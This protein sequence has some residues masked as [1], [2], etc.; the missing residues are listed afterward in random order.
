MKKILSFVLLLAIF[1]T[2][3]SMLPVVSAATVET[4]T[5][6]VEVTGVYMGV[7]EWEDA[8]FTITVTDGVPADYGTLSNGKYNFQYWPATGMM[9][10]TNGTQT[11]GDFGFSFVNGPVANI[12]IPKSIAA[13]SVA[14]KE[15]ANTTNYDAKTIGIKAS[16][17]YCLFKNLATED[18]NN[19]VKKIIFADGIEKI[20][21]AACYKLPTNNKE[22]E[23]I[24]PE[25][26][27]TIG[28]DAFNGGASSC[29]IYTE[30]VIPDSVTSIGGSAFGLTKI[31]TITF[32][33]GITALMDNTLQ[34]AVSLTSVTFKGEVTSLKSGTKGAFAGNKV[35]T[36][37][38]FEGKK[39]PTTMCTITGAGAGKLTIYYPA[40][41]MGYEDETNFRSFFPD[42][43]TF[44][45]L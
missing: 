20:D 32:P 21:N 25:G 31:P 10:I 29:A 23:I 2:Q 3:F 28:S 16:K 27:K 4:V 33:K 39:A 34:N 30:I 43:T 8:T 36:T 40:D 14:S 11:D 7:N 26:L 24:L 17:Y 44:V 5:V 19:D 12:V 6:Q 22:L 38:I 1:L 15:V 41:G 45:P 9:G 18:P 35:L 13:F 37:V 42:T